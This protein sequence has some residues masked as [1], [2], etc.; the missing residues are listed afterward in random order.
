MKR[1][2]FIV[3]VLLFLLSACAPAAETPSITATP[4]VGANKNA[5]VAVAT[6]RGDKLVASDPASVKLGEGK[7]VLVEFFRFT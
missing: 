2:L 3:I 7:P 6:S 5:P 4:A 1:P